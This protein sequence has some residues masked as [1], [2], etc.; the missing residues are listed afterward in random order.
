MGNTA[1]RC[2]VDFAKRFVSQSHIS[3]PTSMSIIGDDDE[4]DEEGAEKG[5]KERGVLTLWIF[6]LL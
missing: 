6:V 4:K 5:R 1:R 3:K 2:N